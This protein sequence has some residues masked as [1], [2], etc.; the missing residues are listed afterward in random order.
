[1]F[2]LASLASLLLL[3]L[4]QSPATA[5]PCL[6]FD[7]NFN[8]LAFGFGGKDLNVTTQDVWATST[9]AADI[10]T[11]GRPPFDGK[12]TT[13]YLA[14]FFNAIY[15]L[16]GDAGNPNNIYIYDATAKSWSTQVT[17]PGS[18]SY[19]SFDAILDH[20]TNVFYAVSGGSLY[21]LDMGTLKAANSTPIAW[22][23]VAKTPYPSDY[24]PVMALAQNHIHFLDVGGNGPGC[25]SIFVIHY[26]YFQPEAQYYSGDKTFPA[27]HGQTASFFMQTGVQQ[28]FAFMSEDF[29]ATYVINVENNN[30]RTLP[31]PTA[32]D[33][34]SS[35]VAGITSL[36]QLDSTGDVYFV[37][38]TP[39]DSVANANAAWSSVKSLTGIV[40]SYN[41]QSNPT[42]NPSNNQRNGSN[43]P[44]NTEASNSDTDGTSSTFP[45]TS[46]L[47]GL[48][49]LFA[50]LGFF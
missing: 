36:V 5:S 1:M 7:V 26:S 43:G 38:Y 27:I 29:S 6:S 39:G 35:Y 30:T 17:T 18:F 9:S 49:A 20:D 25:A 24:V 46:G 41:L 37:P 21:D 8:L 34:D 50:I 45:V 13:C 42:S 2:R 40:S 3:T 31:A 28:E 19:S 15:V 4:S 16:N 23:S 47:V 12:N 32:K 14:Q 10:T 48:A 44:G 22:N 11:T 33:K